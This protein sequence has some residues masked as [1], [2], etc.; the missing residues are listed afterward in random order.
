VS[1]KSQQVTVVDV[2]AG[3]LLIQCARRLVPTELSQVELQREEGPL[4]VRGRVVRSEVVQ[5]AASL[6][7]YR[8]AIAF[9]APLDFIDQA[10][11]AI[12]ATTFAKAAALPLVI[13]PVEGEGQDVMNDW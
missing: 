9:E 1:F 12:D 11:R 2:S 6:L 5:I 10:P 13:E 3:G 4:L 8:I 7:Q